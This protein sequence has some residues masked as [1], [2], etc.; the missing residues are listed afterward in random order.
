MNGFVCEDVNVDENDVGLM[1]NVVVDGNNEVP[2]LELVKVVNC[3][4]TL[5][6]VVN[7]LVDPNVVVVGSKEPE[8]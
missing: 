8:P 5:L 3:E 1:G 2:V 4:V 6:E 7:A